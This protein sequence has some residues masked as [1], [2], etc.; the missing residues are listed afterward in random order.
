MLQLWR[1]GAFDCHKPRNYNGGRIGTCGGHG[2]SRGGMVLVEE[3]VV[4]FEAGVKE[5][6]SITLI[7]EQIMQWE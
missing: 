5:A 2:G 6:P 3:V 7:W 4:E 1:Q